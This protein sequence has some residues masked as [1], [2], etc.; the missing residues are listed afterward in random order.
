MKNLWITEWNLSVNNRTS[1]KCCKLC[2]HNNVQ[3]K[4]VEGSFVYNKQIDALEVVY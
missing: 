1:S 2:P 4:V 3:E